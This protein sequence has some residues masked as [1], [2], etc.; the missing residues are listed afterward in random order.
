VDQVEN[1]SGK[2]QIVPTALIFPNERTAAMSETTLGLDQTEDA[3][4]AFEVSDEAL[5]T[6][7]GAASPQVSFT[8][9]A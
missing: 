9:A 2:I 8:L 7:A 1:Q 6:A 3:L 4:F 5:E